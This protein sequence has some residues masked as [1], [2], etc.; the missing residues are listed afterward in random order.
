MDNKLVWDRVVAN[1]SGNCSMCKQ[2][3][4]SYSWVMKEGNELHGTEHFQLLTES[5]GFLTTSQRFV[6]E[7]TS[8][9]SS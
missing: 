5:D 3:Q 2:N 8:A 7:I 1:V 9:A 4:Y 6:E